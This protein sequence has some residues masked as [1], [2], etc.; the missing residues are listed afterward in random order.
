VASLEKILIDLATDKE[1]FPFQ[2]NEIH[3]IYDS[4]FEKY[5]IN[6]SAMLRYASFFMIIRRAGKVFDAKIRRK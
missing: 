3:S 1:F 6:E 2:G 5:T 4:A